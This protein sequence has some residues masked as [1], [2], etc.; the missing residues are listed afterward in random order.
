GRVIRKTAG[1]V[2]KVFNGR[3]H[4]NVLGNPTKMK[5]ALEYVLLNTSKHMKLVEHFD[6]FSSGP[7]F[8]QWRTLLGRRLNGLIEEQLTY[9]SWHFREL[10]EP[11][12]WLCTVGWMRAH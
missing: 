8:K 7:A 1:G 9:L 10:S 11:R 2:G 6:E 4:M 5:R 12:S 3:F